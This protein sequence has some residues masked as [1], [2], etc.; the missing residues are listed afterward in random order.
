MDEWPKLFFFMSIYVWRRSHCFVW[1]ISRAFFGWYK[2]F[3]LESFVN[4]GLEGIKL[5]FGILKQQSRIAMTFG[6]RGWMINTCVCNNFSFGYHFCESLF[7]DQGRG[8]SCLP[9]TVHLC[10]K[11]DC[12][13]KVQF[14]N[15]WKLLEFKNPFQK[16]PQTLKFLIILF[17]VS[18]SINWTI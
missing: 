7:K 17:T 11:L 5:F 10:E 2:Y 4:G 18:P 13:F 6:A 9:S 16:Y 12:E 14:L 8:P 3:C 1:N 15:F